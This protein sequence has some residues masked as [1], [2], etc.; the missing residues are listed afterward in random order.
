LVIIKKDL[1][2]PKTKEVNNNNNINPNLNI[3]I[4]INNN[5]IFLP[6]KNNLKK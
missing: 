1:N 2:Q 3:N 6:T 4:N 5:I